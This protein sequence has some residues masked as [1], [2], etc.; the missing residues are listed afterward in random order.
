[1]SENPKSILCA[2]FFGSGQDDKFK[3]VSRKKTEEKPKE[4]NDEK[5][6]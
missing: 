1:M 4:D 5:P 2:M 6:E 3:F